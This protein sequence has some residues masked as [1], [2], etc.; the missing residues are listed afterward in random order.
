MI[1]DI[2][3]LSEQATTLNSTALPMTEAKEFTGGEVSWSVVI[4][5]ELFSIRAVVDPDDPLTAPFAYSAPQA[6]PA[7][8]SW[9]W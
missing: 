4:W 5:A 6:V 2:A 7:T 8:P 9:S 3:S 1:R